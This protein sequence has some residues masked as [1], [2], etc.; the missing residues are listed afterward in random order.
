MFKEEKKETNN[1]FAK[2]IILHKKQKIKNKQDKIN[3]AK[4]K[5][6]T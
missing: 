1:N 3:W 4:I 6:C 5:K 2:I